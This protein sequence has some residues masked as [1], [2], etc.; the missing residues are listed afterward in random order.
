MFT[1]RVICFLQVHVGRVSGRVRRNL[2]GP[3]AGP[4]RQASATRSARPRAESQARDTPGRVGAEAPPGPPSD[5]PPGDALVPR[6]GF[7]A[8]PCPPP[9]AGAA[10]DPR[11]V[12]RAGGTP[13]A[14]RAHAA[15]PPRPHLFRPR[16]RK[17]APPPRGS[18]APRAWALRPEGTAGTPP[19]PGRRRH[20]ATARSP[21]AG[22]HR[23]RRELLRGRLREQP[24]EQRQPAEP[25]EQ[26]GDRARGRRGSRPRRARAALGAAAAPCALARRPGSRR[27]GCSGSSSPALREAR[28]QPAALPAPCGPPRPLRLPW[29][30]SNNCRASRILLPPARPPSSLPPAPQ[31]HP[32][33]PPPRPAR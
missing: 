31:P 28:T 7:R 5:N 26:H 32:P 16:G 12:T 24:R 3:R 2:R 11:P 23:E 17:E 21:R 29:L 13:A 1:C 22:T 18:P 15:E 19:D 20:G 27:R 25:G 9:V 6:P 8:R 10:R 14:P 33:R 4:P 30:L